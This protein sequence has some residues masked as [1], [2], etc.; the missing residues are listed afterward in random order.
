MWYFDKKRE[1]I[2]SSMRKRIDGNIYNIG[3]NIRTVR[4][5][6]D[7]TQEQLSEIIGVS[8][9]YISDLE[10]GLVGTSLQTIITLCY[11]LDV[12]ADFILFGNRGRGETDDSI[13]ALFEK[14]Q[15]MPKYKA[16]K[17]AAT[18]K[19]LIEI[20]ESGPESKPDKE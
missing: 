17:I 11:K 1:I 2:G 8:S 13:L 7:L 12:S 18:V 19:E 3:S 15:R 4:K 6:A 9:Q 16:E 20:M 5:Q 14:I 10:R